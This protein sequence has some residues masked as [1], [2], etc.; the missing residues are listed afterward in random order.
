MEVIPLT[1]T[2]HA[3]VMTGPCVQCPSPWESRE[4]KG[5]PS[6]TFWKLIKE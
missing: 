2:V 1:L 6:A 3:E 4:T 5:L